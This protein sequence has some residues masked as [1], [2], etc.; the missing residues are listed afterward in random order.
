MSRSGFEGGGV[1]VA[2]SVAAR[3]R[4]EGAVDVGAYEAQ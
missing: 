3:V 4:I 2:C 1:G